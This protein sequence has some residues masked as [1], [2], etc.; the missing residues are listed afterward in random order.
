MKKLFSTY[1]WG[2]EN[3]GRVVFTLRLVLFMIVLQGL[4]SIHPDTFSSF[5]P[6][7]SLLI[8]LC[9][10]TVLWSIGLNILR[11]CIHVGLAWPWSLLAIVP[12]VNFVFYLYLM[13]KPS[14]ADCLHQA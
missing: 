12:Y 8:I 4:L 5:V 2:L 6:L 9:E 13:L 7:A 14:S 3:I 11:R 10:L 1:F